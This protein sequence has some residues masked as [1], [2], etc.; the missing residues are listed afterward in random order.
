[1]AASKGPNE[2]PSF[3]DRG[4]IVAFLLILAFWMGWSKYM[5]QAYPPAKP[6]EKS[7]SAPT[8]ALTGTPSNTEAP[9]VPPSAPVAGQNPAVETT[10]PSKPAAEEFVDY[11]DDR[12]SFQISSKGMGLRNIDIKPYKT[13]KNEQIV[14]AKLT[15]DYPFATSLLGSTAPVD[16]KVEKTGDGVYVGRAEVAGSIIEKT[17]KVNSANF[18]LDVDV[19]VSATG[20]TFTGLTTTIA[21]TILVQPESKGLP[22]I[23]SETPVDHQVWFINHEGSNKRE[24][25]YKDKGVELNVANISVAALSEHYFAMAVVDRSMLTPRFESRI[26]VGADKAVGQLVYQPPARPASFEQKYVA[27]AGPKDY[28]LLGTVDSNLMKVVDYGMFTVFAKPILWL[29]RTIHDWIGNWGVAIILLTIIV[30]LIVLPFNVMSYKSMKVMQRIQPE[31]T[32]IRDRYK[33]KPAEQKMQM[34]A[35]IMDLMKR[36][37]A[38]PLGG[39]L[40]ML[41]QL[42]VFIALYSVLGQSIELYREPFALWIH[43]LSI[44][45]PYFVLPVLM[46]ITMYV[47]QKITPSTMDPQQAKIM[48]WMPVIFSV[49]MLS[50]PSG[51]TLYI[52][53][54]TLFGIIQQMIFMRDKGSVQTTKV[55]KA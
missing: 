38:N 50:L 14:L 40:P 21:D 49:F 28:S 24:T 11:S 52:F 31:M 54:S 19:K 17:M 47:N 23:G 3:M 5:E 44:R 35:E 13:R 4:T 16:F 15:S 8:E 33:D 12:W 39:C 55:A 7:A 32:R 6:T 26:A 30:R 27:F 22:I 41:I 37:K 20:P 46:G 45:D 18:S 1:M 42:P 9:T 43:D 29:L 53:I 48:M 2:K 10:S 25:V 51:L 34:N 36:N